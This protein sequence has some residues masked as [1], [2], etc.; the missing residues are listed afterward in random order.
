MVMEKLGQPL[1]VLHEQGEMRGERG[2]FLLRCVVEALAFVHARGVVHR[3][4]KLMNACLRPAYRGVLERA[5]LI[6]FEGAALVPAPPGRLKGHGYGTRGFFAPEVLAGLSYG[7]AVDVYA[8]GV[9]V[10]V[11]AGA[12]HEDTPSDQLDWRSCPAARATA[13]AMMA[14]RPASRP[15]AAALL[16]VGWMSPPRSS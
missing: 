3:D 9:C 5:V 2:R 16:R 12:G 8:A 6:D 11:V 14:E 13:V 1:Q 7:P 10:Q 15:A 4:V